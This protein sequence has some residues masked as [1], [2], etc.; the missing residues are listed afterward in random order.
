MALV[1]LGLITS[2]WSAFASITSE[3]FRARL[4]RRRDG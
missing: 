1:M 4:L 2:G 3:C